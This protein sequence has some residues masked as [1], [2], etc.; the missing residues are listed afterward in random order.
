MFFS[1]FPFH[2]NT[3]FLSHVLIF[4]SL[5]SFPKIITDN[6]S[7]LQIITNNQITFPNHFRQIKSQI[8]NFFFFFNKTHITNNQIK[9][10]KNLLSLF[11]LRWPHFSQTFL[12]SSH[13]L[14]LW[15]SF[16]A[17]NQHFM[18][19]YQVI[20]PQPKIKPIK[21]QPNIKPIKP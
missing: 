17:W 19:Q 21:P 10:T 6:K 3:Q 18:L 1:W 8:H 20:K 7:H 9:K 16:S 4:V 14:H 12:F 5:P 15:C 11:S 2:H 13:R